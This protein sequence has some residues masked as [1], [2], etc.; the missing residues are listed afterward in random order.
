[1]SLQSDER[2]QLDE[3]FV[4]LGTALETLQETTYK[5][6]FPKLT[7][8]SGSRGWSSYSTLQRCPRAFE[9]RYERPNFKYPESSGTARDVG[10]GM[11]AFLAIHYWN[12]MQQQP[13]VDLRKVFNDLLRFNIEV[14]ALEE[15]WRLFV[16]YINFYGNEEGLTPLGIEVPAIDGK[17]GNSCRYDLIVDWTR[18]P[19]GFQPG[20]FIFEHKTASAFSENTLSSWDIDGEIL[21]EVALWE[22]AG[23]VRKYGPLQGICINIIGKQKIPKFQR[24]W[25]SPESVQTEQHLS[26]LQIWQKMI[27]KYREAQYWPRALTGC[28]TRYGRC[29]YYDYCASGG[30]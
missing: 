3:N 18:P 26:D 7:G 12:M 22:K 1:M 14:K 19:L 11:H 24:V 17:T 16:A 15:A 13:I 28:V 8:G 27:P 23:M 5:G 2:V 25:I 9:L 30:K 4:S 10:S 20:I 21:G 6:L 29:G